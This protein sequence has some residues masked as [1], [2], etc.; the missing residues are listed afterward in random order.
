MLSKTVVGKVEKKIFLV[1]YS[2]IKKEIYISSMLGILI[3]TSYYSN[4]LFTFN[5]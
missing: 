4:K 2:F 5:C 1:E 3:L